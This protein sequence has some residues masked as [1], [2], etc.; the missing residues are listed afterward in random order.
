MLFV[1]Y[2]AEH[3]NSGGRAGIIVPEGIVFKGESAYKQLR[4]RLIEECLVAVVSLPAGVFNPYSGVKTS[5]LLLDKSLARRTDSIAFFK[6]EHDG[7]DLGAQRLPIDKNDLPQVQ[8]KITEHLRRAK[9][10]ETVDSVIP[11]PVSLAAERGEEYFASKSGEQNG[12][13][14]EKKR[15]AANGEF[16][17]F[18]ERYREYETFRHS[19]WPIVE[20][21]D[22]CDAILSGGTP[23]TKEEEYWRGDIPWITSADIVDLKTAVPRRYITEQAIEESATN[24]IRKGNVIVVT[25]V[26]LGKLF[27]NGFDVCISQDSQGLIVNDQ[28]NSDFLVYVLRDRVKN[29]KEMSQGSTIQGVTKNQLAEL[30]IPLPP[31]EVQEEIVAEIEGYQKVIDGARAVVERMERK[32]QATI[33][34]VWSLEGNTND[35]R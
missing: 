33:G 17:L 22:V 31:M 18:G 28:I 35:E 11:A 24:L 4:K 9:N 34:R 14:I 5:I 20:L 16:S 29:F 15:I 19:K 3:L 6:V 21:K 25:R 7:F 2:I 23:S 12:L 8:A 10:G 26:G 32:I 13:V 30:R 1:D 27:K